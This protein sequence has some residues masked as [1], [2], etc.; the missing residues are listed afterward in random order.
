MEVL[1]PA[2]APFS[3]ENTL[4][5]SDLDGNTVAVIEIGGNGNAGGPVVLVGPVRESDLDTARR[6]SPGV[7]VASAPVD[8]SLSDGTSDLGGNAEVCLRVDSSVNAD[9]AC[10]GYINEAGRWECE[11]PCVERRGN[12]V[13]GR[14]SHLTSFAVLLGGNGAGE[15]CGGTND[16]Y[17]T[18]TY[19]GDIIL[20]SGAIAF[21]MSIVACCVVLYAAWPAFRMRIKGGESRRAQRKWMRSRQMKMQPEFESF[22]SEYEDSSG[23][24]SSA[25]E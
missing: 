3:E 13:C 25:T 4:V 2:P 19:W 5:V 9:D 10:L 7:R 8:I 15:G 18:G 24:A 16:P 1:V 6:S 22:L 21:A 12:L 20:T 14:T 17:V 23:S 11:D